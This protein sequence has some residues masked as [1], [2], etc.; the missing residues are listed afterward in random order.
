[1]INELLQ[2]KTAARGHDA[3]LIAVWQEVGD[4]I[5]ANTLLHAEETKVWG[6]ASA[7]MHETVCAG[8]SPRIPEPVR[9]RGWG[10]V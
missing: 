2:A 5:K 7:L 10:T 9:S 8:I 1:M 3:T 6:D 4:V